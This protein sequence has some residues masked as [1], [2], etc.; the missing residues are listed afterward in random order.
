MELNIAICDDIEMFCNELHKQLDQIEDLKG[1]NIYEFTTSRNF[2]NSIKTNK[3]DIVFM[4][5][6]LE[7]HKTGMDLSYLCKLSNPDCLIIYVS[8]YNT[9]FPEMVKAEPFYFLSKPVEFQLLKKAVKLAIRRIY[10]LRHR[11]MYTYKFNGIQ[12]KI[13]LQDVLYF[14][15]AHRIIKGYLVNENIVSF[16]DKLDKVQKDI[17]VDCPIFLRANKSYLV[18]YNFCKFSTGSVII[19]GFEIKIS[20]KYKEQFYKKYWELENI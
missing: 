1:S 7:E 13:N 5:V 20:E 16:Y 18:N 6:D 15:S 9:Y 17:E 12:H 4:D 19:D 14:E 3:Y 2:I 11:F 8:S 10:L